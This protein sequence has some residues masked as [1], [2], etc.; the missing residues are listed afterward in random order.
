VNLL[1]GGRSRLTILPTF[2][3]YE[4]VRLEVRR[5]KGNRGGENRGGGPLI[6]GPVTLE[7]GEF[8]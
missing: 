5:R 4:V 1:G 7:G 6:Y 2:P 8:R 3:S